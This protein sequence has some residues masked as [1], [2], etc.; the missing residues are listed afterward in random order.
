MKFHQQKR[1][2]MI[3]GDNE[4]LFG[5]ANQLLPALCGCKLTGNTYGLSSFNQQTF[6][7]YMFPGDRVMGYGSP[8]TPGE[9]DEKSI[10]F[11]GVNYL[12][13]GITVCV[14]VKED[15]SELP[16]DHPLTTVATSSNGKPVICAMERSEKGGRVVVDT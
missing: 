9:F 8:H 2:L 16:K 1:G 15:G 13:E 6:I 11:A 14:P 5:Q 12:Y 10:L 3:W 4:P 7:S